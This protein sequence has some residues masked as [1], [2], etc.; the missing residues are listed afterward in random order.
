MTRPAKILIRIGVSLVAIIVVL[1][2]AALIVVQTA[3]FQNFARTKIASLIED[4]TGGRVEIGSFSFSLR[5]LSVNI[6]NF[7]LHGT[8]PPSAAPLLRI[9][10][11]DAEVKLIPSF[12]HAIDLEHLGVTTP[13]AN[14]LVFPNGK[15]NIPT[16]KKKSTPS[17]NSGLKT[18]MDLAVKHFELT[19]G[20]IHFRQES[21]PVDVRGDNLAVVL[22]YDTKSPAY[23]GSLKLDPIV[24][25]YGSGTPL[26]AHLNVPVRIEEDAVRI[27]NAR[28]FTSQSNITLSADMEHMASPAITGKT[29][30]H[31]SIPE[32]EQSLNLRRP[33]MPDGAPSAAD[34]Q[35]AFTMDSNQID[36]QTA[37]L[38]LGESKLQ[39]SG[40]LKDPTGQGSLRF[41]GTLVLTQLA[42]LTGASLQPQGNLFLDGKAQ[43][44]P[45]G[46]YTV[47]GKLNGPDLSAKNGAQRLGPVSIAASFRAVPNLLQLPGL[48]IR[49]FGGELLGKAD[50]REMRRFA[51]NLHVSE[52]DLQKLSHDLGYKPLGYSGRLS[53][54]L[55][56]NGDLKA[57]GMSGDTA[58]LLL[59][60]TGGNSGIPVNGRI[61]A[62][63]SG[64]TETVSLERS[65]LTLPHTR[66]ELAGVLGHHLNLN[67]LSKNLHDFAPVLASASS[68][69]ANPQAM[70]IT[71]QGGTAVVDANVDGPMRSPEIAATAQMTN[72]AVQGRTFDKFSASL[73]ATAGDA[74]LTQGILQRQ[75]LQ[76]QF[77]GGIGLSYWKTT[78]QSPLHVSASIHNAALEDLVALAGQKD[79]PI[80]GTLNASAN[81]TGTLGNPLGNAT[82]DVSNATVYGEAVQQAKLALRFS[83]QLVQ[84]Q[85]LEVTSGAAQLTASAIYKHPKD[86]LSNGHLQFNVA[87]NTISLAQL[88]ALESRRPGVGGT[89]QLSADV[90]ADIVSDGK[91]RSI[92]PRAINADLSAKGLKDKADNY[93]DLTASAKTTNQT[94]TFGLQSNLAG[95]RTDVNGSAQLVDGYPLNLDASIHSLNL[96]K[97]LL[98]ARRPDVPVQ[99]TLSATAHIEGPLKIP[100]GDMSVNLTKAV[101]YGEPINSLNGQLVYET[102]RARIPDFRLDLPAGS[103][104][105]NGDYTHP[106][107]NFQQGTLT[108]RAV[109]ESLKV[110]ELHTIQQMRPG[111]KGTLRLLADIDTG[112]DLPNKKNPLTIKKLDTTLNADAIEYNGQN[113]GSF[114]LST[115]TTGSRVA[116]TLNS[117]LAQASLKGQG[118]VALSPG[119]PCKPH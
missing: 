68:N 11:L 72:F 20:T 34:A 85:P 75:S 109:S 30:V 14:I 5:H 79:K 65:Y 113:F 102:N 19:N 8:E 51:A 66:L 26:T 62:E 22:R 57:K 55:T 80:A 86:S 108:L 118:D 25:Q 119:Y 17:N 74:R 94:V 48:S 77:N 1:I 100:Q 61:H 97:V 114:D 59:R 67:L 50:L 45:N 111:L 105:F 112:V 49:G 6:K 84:L 31:I 9:A 91:S 52:F 47:T 64:R 104:R 106:A 38:T 58:N 2:I 44:D 82:V 76:A 10:S 28:L 40:K 103:L 98:L 42:E 35:V 90:A 71:M 88:K 15:T 92:L 21:I 81:V 32:M 70:P 18:V 12:H 99:G 27:Q 83:D 3:W 78:P 41:G 93:G 33:P 69:N 23:D 37:S 4:S 53:G 73:H 107:G 116:L 39:A 56:A 96:E 101:V 54:D 110:G 87:T 36:V 29:S 117:D 46:G 115:K 13:A 89:V 63:F 24:S 95:S 43:I 7:V 60:V 16:P